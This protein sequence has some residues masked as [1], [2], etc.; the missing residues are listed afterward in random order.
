MNERIEKLIEIKKQTGMSQEAMA[1]EI[2]VSLGS[3]NRWMKGKFEPSVHVC[4][5]I[6]RF[7]EKHK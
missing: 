1:R 5:L 3:V 2:G 7:I 6:D 4:A